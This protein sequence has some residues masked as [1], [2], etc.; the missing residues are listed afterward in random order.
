MQVVLVGDPKQLGPVIKSQIAL[1]FG[2]NISLLER[3]TSRELYLRDED[4]FSTCGAYNPLL[5]RTMILFFSP[6]K[7][8]R[9]NSI[10]S[11]IS[12]PPFCFLMLSDESSLSVS[13]PGSL[14]YLEYIL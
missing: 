13:S 2:L 9:R 4:A 5:V 6:P 14:D 12:L 10:I 7:S 1:A 11:V 8:K 3:L